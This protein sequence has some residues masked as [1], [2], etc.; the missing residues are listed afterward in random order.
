M[1]SEVRPDDLAAVR[2]RAA[3]QQLV[4]HDLG[5]ALDPDFLI[6]NL[7]AGF[8]AKNPGRAWLQQRDLR[9]AVAAAVD[10]QA[11]ADTVFLG[12]GVPV[13]GPV[14]P[15]NRAWY[16]PA[17]PQPAHDPAQ[18][19]QL[20]AGIGL[21]DRNGDGVLEAPAGMPAGF[22]LLTQKGNTLRERSAAFLQDELGKIGLKV[23]VVT[24]DYP[25]VIER[26]MKGD[27][28]AIYF[29]AQA[30]DTDPASNLDF[31][32]SSGAFHPWNPG[33]TSP[34]T[35]WERRI[36]DLMKAQV[37]A[38]GI[39]ERRRLFNQVQAI[40]AEEVPAL[41]FVAP[42]VSVATAP[43]V[44]HARPALLQPSVLWNADMLSVR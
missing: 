42:R 27:Y 37:A 16:D 40:F 11:F 36:D 38:P 4:L 19:R 3:Q 9:R 6:F 43:R 5:V 13:S 33:Q 30:S 10:R 28:E 32:V 35:A 18:A 14:T 44:A 17:L 34:A 26:L 25:S 39:E 2:R 24:L 29:G 12:A 41:Y 7:Q 1:S 8:A 15:G 22:S 21:R 31:W 20:L 23:D